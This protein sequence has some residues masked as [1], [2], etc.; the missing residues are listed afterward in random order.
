MQEYQ[1]KWQNLKASYTILKTSH[2]STT[3]TLE[4]TKTHSFIYVKRVVLGPLSARFE[5][6]PSDLEKFLGNFTEKEI[7]ESPTNVL[8]VLIT[9]NDTRGGAVNI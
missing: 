8:N 4:E 7:F 3:F 6:L 2:D 1:Q 5:G 9:M